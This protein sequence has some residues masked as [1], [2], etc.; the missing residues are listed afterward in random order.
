MLVRLVKNEFERMWKETVVVI[1]EILSRNWPH[2]TE[3]NHESLR[4]NS[5]YPG[6]VL[7][8]APS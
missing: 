2:R 7:N 3:V 4:P 5:L 8:P 6:H 1:R